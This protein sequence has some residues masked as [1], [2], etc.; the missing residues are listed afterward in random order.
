MRHRSIPKN[1]NIMRDLTEAHRS[2][3]TRS[4]TPFF[5][6]KED[7]ASF[8]S[9]PLVQTKLSIGQPGDKYEREADM[10]AEHVVSRSAGSPAVQSKCSACEAEE[11]GPVLTKLQR[12]AMEEEEEMQMKVQRQ[13]M[14]EEEE[15]Q[16]KVQRMGQTDHPEGFVDEEE[17]MLNQPTQLK[18]GGAPAEA[19]MDLEGRLQQ[20]KGGGA[21]L[22]PETQH[23]MSSAFG[24]DF[25][26]VRVHTGSSAVQMNKELSAQAF[27]H[28]SDV[29]FNSGKYD[30]DSGE[31]KKLLA[32]ELT[33]V[34]QQGA[35]KLLV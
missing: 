32:H 33:H 26:R 15:M 14:Q 18:S 13:G 30:P 16:M 1:I 2:H 7:D 22:R 27:T 25:S 6:K 5:Q 17:M 12:Q 8:F 28:G 23:E 3:L 29:Y 4:N 24:A 31:G 34:V 10:M 21:P 9:T 11:K 35:G 20:H 19:S